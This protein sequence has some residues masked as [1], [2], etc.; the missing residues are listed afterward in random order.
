MIL[1]KY[2]N[3][4]T[5]KSIKIRIKHIENNILQIN[6]HEAESTLHRRQGSGQLTFA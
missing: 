6:N 1:I 4:H 3:S 5:A 2:H